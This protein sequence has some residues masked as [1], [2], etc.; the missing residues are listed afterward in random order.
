MTAEGLERAE[1]RKEERR[2]KRSGRSETDDQA[3]LL[4][5]HNTAVG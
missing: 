3:A 4:S 1:E 2:R 5:Q